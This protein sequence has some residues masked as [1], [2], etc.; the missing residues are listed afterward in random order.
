VAVVL[1]AGSGAEVG[2][3]IVES[4]EVYVVYDAAGWDF[5]YAAMHVDRGGSAFSAYPRV[6]LSVECVAIFG[7]VPF[8]LH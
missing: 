2:G 8:V 6:A 1:C 5:Y 4:V 7:Y 3:S